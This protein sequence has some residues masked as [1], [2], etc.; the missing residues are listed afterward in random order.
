ML[1]MFPSYWMGPD[2]LQDFLKNKPTTVRA[3]A[4][5]IG[6]AIIF[7]ILLVTFLLKKSDRR[8]KPDTCAVIIGVGK[9]HLF[10]AS[11]YYQ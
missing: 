1:S 6:G 2:V 9:R 10:P 5:K 3:G 7:P 8:K 4:G 11:Y